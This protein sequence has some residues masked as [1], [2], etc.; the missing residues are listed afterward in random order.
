[1]MTD[2]A[3]YWNDIKRRGSNFTPTH[4]KGFECGIYQINTTSNLYHVDCHAC[5]E[6]INTSSELTKQREI[7]KIK[8]ER[9]L[10]IGRRK[11]KGYK[12]S[13]HLKFGKYKGSNKPL[14]WIIE[15]DKSYFAWMQG[16][17]LFHPEVD[18]FIKL[19]TEVNNA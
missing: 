15:N 13:S 10:E 12:L 1:M 14:S 2:T 9:S 18:K 5:N 6:Y 7:D 17:V 16:K 19:A 4:I 11:K 3:D 8:W